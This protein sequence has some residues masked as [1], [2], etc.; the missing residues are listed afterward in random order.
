MALFSYKTVT[1]FTFLS[2]TSNLISSTLK[3]QLSFLLLSNLTQST[4]FS[5]LLFKMGRAQ[6]SVKKKIQILTFLRESKNI[7][8][9]A[10]HFSTSAIT[11]R[12]AQ[13]R[14][15][16]KQEH[17]LI[18]K[19]TTNPKACS[20]HHGRLVENVALEKDV[21]DWIVHQRE[22]EIAVSTTSIISK[23]LSLDS[24]F[25]DHDQKKLQH[26]VY[27]F[28]ARWKLTCRMA[29]RVGQKLNGH[30][31]SVREGFSEV[32]RL[33]FKSGG[34]YETVPSSRF[35]NMDETAVFF[36]AKPKS[37]VH[38]IGD[39][40]VSVRCT[41][42]NSRRMTVCVSVAC[43]G[44]KL[45]LFVIFK[46][47]PNGKIEK[48]LDNILPENV[49]GCCQSKGWMDERSMKI[50]TDLVWKPYVADY[51]RSVLLLDD[52][53]CHKQDCLLEIMESVGTHVELIPG[54][55]TCV[56][57]PCDVG[58]IR[59]LKNG[60]RKH[61]MEWAS[62][63]YL[64][65]DTRSSLPAPNKREVSLWTLNSFN[66]IS[67]ECVRATF[68]HIGFTE[69]GLDQA[70]TPYPDT[71]FPFFNDFDN[72]SVADLDAVDINQIM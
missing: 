70:C 8:A 22:A 13:I 67:E 46:G 29:T 72:N 11:I 10:R 9:T 17:F 26:W 41:G 50:W 52:F 23:A 64:T 63:K 40:T 71:P 25:K 35:V 21:F 60:I 6:L 39:N 19:M 30:L 57:Q 20:I 14:V 65:V 55:Y 62:A 2:K 58:V 18:E 24:N 47:Q 69:I 54:G 59:S 32:L 4:I 1:S 31:L 34:A 33:K 61:Y 44:T 49:F 36:E 37:T 56:L 16:I 5:L 7:K 27:P 43:D 3:K 66:A 68:D 38:M 53:S 12:P 15:W 28:M 45:P 51:E 42:S 48:D